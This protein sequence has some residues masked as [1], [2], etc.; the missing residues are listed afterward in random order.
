[1]TLYDLIYFIGC[2]VA[3]LMSIVGLCAQEKMKGRKYNVAIIIFISFIPAMLSW[4]L[5]LFGG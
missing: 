4:A 2:G 1:M 5:H 3:L